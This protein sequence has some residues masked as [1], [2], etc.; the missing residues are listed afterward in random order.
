MPRPLALCLALL[1]T[2]ASAAVGDEQPPPNVLW[3]IA[4][5]MSPHLGCY[6]PSSR[7]EG[8][9]HTPNIDRLAERGVRF[10]RAFTTAPVCSASRSAFMTGMYQTSIGAHN[11][12]SNRGGNFPLPDGVRVLT[13]WLRPHDIYTANLRKLPDHAEIGTVRG[14]GKTDWNFTYQ[15]PATGDEPYDSDRWGDLKT[16]QPFYAQI[17]FSET[18]RGGAWNDSHKLI[19]ETADPAEVELP[20]YYPDHPVVRKDWAQYLN[21]VM[22]LDRKVGHVLDLLERDGLAENTVV[23]FFSDHGAAHVRSKQ[24]PYDSGLHVPLIVRFPDGKAPAGV[25]PGTTDDRLVEAIDFAPTTLALMGVDVPPKMQGRDLFDPD[26][27]PRD[28]AFAARDRCDET[29]FRIRTLRD[30]RYRYIRNFLNDRPFLLLNRYKETSYPAIPVMRK[31]AG[32]GKLN[33]IQSRLTDPGPR[34]AEE[35]Y[36]LE[37]DPHEVVN[38]VDSPEHRD[39][40]ER[41]RRDLDEKLSATGD[42]GRELEPWSAVVPWLKKSTSGRY[43]RTLERFEEQFPTVYPLGERFRNETYIGSH[44]EEK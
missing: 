27:E 29:V 15:N 5:D 13:D 37:F 32:E 6:G 16:H 42:R 28:Y 17:N 41:M 44:P 24:W 2:C 26:A 21:T 36:D 7:G 10:T 20:P 30:C 38:L 19:D 35:L 34:P 43:R 1:S 18:H 25:E 8:H 3:I 40:L 4:E 33:A 11:H 12:R 31:L 14:S 39:V 9:V 22:A 23:V